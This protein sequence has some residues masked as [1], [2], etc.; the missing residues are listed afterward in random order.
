MPTAL[1]IGKTDKTTHKLDI[2]EIEK[3]LGDNLI[4]KSELEFGH[5]GFLLAQDMTY[6]GDIIRLIKS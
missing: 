5:S 6:I 3:E 1:F 4:F 2:E